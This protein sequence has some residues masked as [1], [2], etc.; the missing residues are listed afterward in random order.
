MEK[1]MDDGYENAKEGGEQM[2]IKTERGNQVQAIA[3]ELMVI[4]V[5]VA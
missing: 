3:G 5:Y 4:V 1:W 2:K